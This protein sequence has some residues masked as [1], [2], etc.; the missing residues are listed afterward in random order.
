MFHR[1]RS[2]QDR[3]DWQAGD[4]DDFY[5]GVTR[6]AISLRRFRL[7][8]IK[9]GIVIFAVLDWPI[10]S[11]L[12]FKTGVNLDFFPIGFGRVQ[13]RHD[14][15]DNYHYQVTGLFEGIDKG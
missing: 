10:V 7:T 1:D 12:L 5:R 3:T 14:V 15:R 8:Q 6:I 13:G 4:A 2:G 11:M 9:S